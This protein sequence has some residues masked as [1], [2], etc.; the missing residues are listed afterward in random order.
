MLAAH[1]DNRNIGNVYVHGIAFAQLA[2]ALTYRFEVRVVFYIAYNAA[3][4]AH[5]DVRFGTV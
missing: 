1:F 3:D 5:D 4:L 2:A